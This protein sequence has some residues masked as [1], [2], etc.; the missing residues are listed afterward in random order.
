MQSELQLLSQLSDLVYLASDFKKTLMLNN[1]GK[2]TDQ[3]VLKFREKIRA[4]LLAMQNQLN[5]DYSGKIAEFILFPIIANVDEKFMLLITERELP[6]HW[7]TLQAEFYG[8]TDGGEFVFDV[9]DEVLSNKIYPKISYEVLL[10]VLQD[11][12]LGK[13]Y[14]NPNHAERHQYISRVK[15]ILKDFNQNANI[16][17]E[18]VATTTS[19]QQMPNSRKAQNVVWSVIAICILVP[20]GIYFFA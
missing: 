6:C 1:A 3:E 16:N 11:N 15:S 7:D 14:Q 9:L 8:R 2:T 19:R 5:T 20:L 4:Q 13:Y 18:A 12:F 10:M 17:E